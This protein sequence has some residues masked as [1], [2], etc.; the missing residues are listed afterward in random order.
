[1]IKKFIKSFVDWITYPFKRIKLELIME[2][3]QDRNDREGMD[4]WYEAMIEWCALTKSPT[5]IYNTY[6]K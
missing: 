6:V 1:M 4:K 2:K 3:Y 5:H